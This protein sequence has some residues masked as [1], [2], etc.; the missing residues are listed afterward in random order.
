MATKTTRK[1]GE[2]HRVAFGETQLGTARQTRV[3]LTVRT[4]DARGSGDPAPVDKEIGLESGE[5]QVTY[6]IADETTLALL[7]TYDTLTLSDSGGTAVFTADCLLKDLQRRESH[8]E[9][10]IL[11]ALFTVQSIPTVPDLSALDFTA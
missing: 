7:G 1:S 5:V 11:D 4:A 2:N 10:T 8:D 9:M 3:R 6:L